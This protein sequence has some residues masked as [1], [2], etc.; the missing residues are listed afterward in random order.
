ME[1][2]ASGSKKEKSGRRTVGPFGKATENAMNFA[3][4]VTTVSTFHNLANR[5]EVLEAV[6]RLPVVSS[7]STT[8]AYNTRER[9]EQEMQE[10]E[11]ALGVFCGLPD[12]PEA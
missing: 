5:I 10:I 8:M 11:Y 4:G 3:L 12:A 7:G 6:M 1:N 9:Y 2:S